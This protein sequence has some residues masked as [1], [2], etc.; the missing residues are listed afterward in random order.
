MKKSATVVALFLIVA[1]PALLQAQP[2]AFPGAE[3]FGK[4]SSGGRGGKVA[5]VTTLADS[6]PGSLRWAVEQFP[7]EPLTVVFRISGI[8]DLQSEIRLH[9]SFVTIAGQTA[10][11]DGICLKGNSFIINGAG[12]HGQAN[13]IIIRY[14]RFRPGSYIAHGIYGLDMENC[15]EVIIDHCSF[16]WANEENAALY[17][18]KN[19]TVQW[20]ISSEGLYHANHHKGNRS[21]SGVWGGQYAS[22]HHN[23]IA[24][25]N[26][27]TVRFDGSRAHDTIALVDY[28]NNVIYNWHT[29][30]GCYGGEVEIPG[31]QSSIN[32][33]NNYYKPG[34]AT[35]SKL[36]FA[37]A[38]SGDEKSK[39]TGQWY[40]EGNK[41][42]GDKHLTK[43]NYDGLDL[44]KIPAG[45]R[46]AARAKS[47]FKI[48]DWATVKTTP[49][50]DAFKAVLAGAGAT[51]PRRDAVDARI[52]EG[53]KAGTATGAGMIGN[54]I[55]DNPDAVGG[56]PTYN[57]TTPPADSDHDGMPDSWEKCHGLNPEDASDG[58]KTS[59]TGYT[60]L[61]DYLNALPDA[62]CK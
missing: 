35:P 17:D 38:Y 42:D 37:E 34:P 5:E 21:Y 22:Y 27:R 50:D 49:T 8:I 43:N 47:I 51:L 19:T 28:R 6:G 46:D 36:L 54:G 4:Y 16:C 31:G 26:T 52:T 62:G 12:V 41:M 48:P 53:A 39:G 20:C 18:T 32:M 14:L 23:L 30:G 3:G 60:N 44:D 25:N 9:R 13:N 61:E 57:S 56:W 59:S 2:L 55:I 58:G 29:A 11:G 10:P 45:E 40:L 33:I 24:D 15:H 1:L 7:G